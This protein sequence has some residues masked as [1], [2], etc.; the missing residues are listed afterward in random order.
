[1]TKRIKI[2]LIVSIAIVLIATTVTVDK[3][4]LHSAKI[5]KSSATANLIPNLLLHTCGVR[6]K[7][8]LSEE[9]QA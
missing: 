8:S 9:G 2:T 4:L 7:L 6:E 1:M 5:R 3:D